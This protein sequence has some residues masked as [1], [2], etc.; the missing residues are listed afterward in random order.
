[1]TSF[2]SNIQNN[3][4]YEAEQQSSLTPL[5]AVSSPV[6]SLFSTL[7]LRPQMTSP[8]AQY[9]EPNQEP[10]LGFDRFTCVMTPP[11]K[12]YRSFPAES[13]Q[14]PSFGSSL[15]FAPL[16]PAEQ[17][18]L[19]PQLP[20][21]PLLL[22]ISLPLLQIKQIEFNAVSSPLILGSTWSLNC[23]EG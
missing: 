16:K 10:Q 1:M 22:H 7:V 6:P 12:R 2:L 8:E 21:K 11:Q 20:Q 18:E 23:K 3:C 13:S 15:K 17:L 5:R 19:V 9:L 4:P 14:E